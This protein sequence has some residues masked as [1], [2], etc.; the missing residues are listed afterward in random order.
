MTGMTT[1]RTGRWIDDWKPEDETFWATKGAKIAR[2][3]L[4]WSIFA[5]HLG[6]SIWVIWS[7][8]AAFLA[9]VGFDFTPQQLF[10]LVAIPSLVGALLRLPYTFAVP[11]FGGRNWTVFSALALLVPTAGFA[12]AVTHPATPYWAFCVIAAFAGLGGGN[13]ASSMTNINFFYPSSKKGTALGLNAAGGNLGVALI[14]FLLPVMVG[15][16]GIFGLVSARESGIHLQRAAYVYAVLCLVAAF[17]A[18]RFMDNLGT[19]KSSPREQLLALK[20]KHTWIMALIY[21]GTFGS[22]MGYSSAMP[23]LIKLNF[24]RQP[25]PAVHGIGINFAYYAFLGALVGSLTRPLGGWLADKYGGARITVAAFGGMILGTLGVLFALSHLQPLP[26]PPTGA[27]L[28]AIK[29]DPAG[30]SFKP[31]LVATVHDN[32]AVFPW[33]LLAFL[34]VFAATGIGNGS[35][36]KMIPALFKRDAE[37]LTTPGSLERHNALVAAG[38][39][40]SAALGIIGAVGALG[41]FLIPVSFN[42]PWVTTPLAATKSAFVAFTV[43]YV[44]CAVVCAAVYLRPRR[45]SSTSL[46]TARI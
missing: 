20:N 7:V 33:F 36:Y 3:N 18:Y 6:F 14:Q 16:A 31:E 35:A 45:A 42:S 24:W 26:A 8:S 15:G 4:I 1:R 9:A 30:F 25:I 17:A 43:F 23:L 2:R 19:A 13:F 46:A 21:I 28:A 5:E 12:I 11:A 29:A 44:I 34:F 40:S 22:F 38:K 32:S 37:V 39:Q 27:A 41:G 10:F